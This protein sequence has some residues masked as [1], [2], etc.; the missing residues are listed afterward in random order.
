MDGESLQDLSPPE[1]SRHD[2]M[3]SLLQETQAVL[4]H[5]NLIHSPER[6]FD[7]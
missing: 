3:A 1:P 2:E 6:N 5:L 4:I 7:Q